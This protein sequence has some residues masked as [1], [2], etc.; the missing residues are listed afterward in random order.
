MNEDGQNF[1]QG[2]QDTEAQLG[3]STASVVQKPVSGPVTWQASEYIDHEKDGI[4]FVGMVGITLVLAALSI[5]LIKSWTF[6]A[7]ILVMAASV[8]V[9]ARRPPRTLDYSLSLHGLQ[10]NEKAYSL[11]DFRAFGIIQEGPLYSV[12]LIP[13]K[14]FMP[15]VNVYFPQEQGEQIVDLLGATIPM[16]TVEPDAIDTLVRKLRF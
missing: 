14:R 3:A 8:A 16:E 9:Y 15:S 13:V 5:F 2:D 6:T 12:V 4:W 10:V 7:L 11:S 1:W